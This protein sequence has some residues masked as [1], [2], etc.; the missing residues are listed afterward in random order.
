MDS[1]IQIG[2]KNTLAEYMILSGVDNRPPILD[3]DLVTRTKKYAELSATKK[4][5]A[6]CDLKATSI[7]LQGETKFLVLCPKPKRKI[8]ATWFRDKVLLVEAKGNGKVLNEEELEFL[9]DPGIAEGQVTQSV[10]THNAA[11]QADDL[12]AYDS[13]CDEISTAKAVLMAN[14]SSYGSDVLSEYL[15]ES[16]NAAIQDTNSSTQQDALILSVFEQLSNQVTNCNKVNNDNLIANDSLSAEL[17]RYKEQVK[18]L[19]ERQ[20][21]DL[22]NPNDQQTNSETPINFDS[23]DED[24]EPTPQPKT[25]NP[26]TVKETPLPKPYKPKISYPQRLR[27]EKMEAQYEKFLDVIRAVQINVP[28]IDVLAGMPIMENFSRN[29]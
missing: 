8:D 9:A 25:Q 4:N 7:I 16:Q 5:Q 24:E 13:D 6:D 15:I 20:N 11:Y 26:K 1:I 22:V 23:D 19:E 29:S 28:L 12:D 21:V 27:K 17:E 14:L 10:I 2:Q 3:K 18:L